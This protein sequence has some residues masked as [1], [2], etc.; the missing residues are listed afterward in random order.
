[1]EGMS[2]VPLLAAAFIAVAVASVWL[3]LPGT[4]QWVL[5]FLIVAAAFVATKILTTV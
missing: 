3:C 5:L 4:K 1:M 2:S